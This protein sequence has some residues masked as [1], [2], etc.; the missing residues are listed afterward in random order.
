MLRTI[1]LIL[2]AQLCISA[3]DLG[4]G[5]RLGKFA[6]ASSFDIMPGGSILVC[7]TEKNELI[8]LSPDGNTI[9]SVGGYGWDGENFDNPVHVFATT[10]NVYVSDLNN[11]RIQIFDKDLNYLS[12]FKS[13][14]SDSESETFAYPKSC[15]VSNQGDIFVLDGDNQR[16]L[17]YDLSGRFLQEIGNTDSGEYALNSPASLA[18]SAASKLFVPDNSAIKIFDLFGTGLLKFSVGFD[19][20]AIR[21]RNNYISINSP[22]KIE[23]L[24]LSNSAEKLKEFTPGFGNNEIIVESIITDNFI[25]ILTSNYIIKFQR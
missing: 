6:H 8:K 24:D 25:Y 20:A 10:L 19:V 16:V 9:K 12:E 4:N 15:V 13:R 23:F 2:I 21:I 17:K 11:H 22:T 7:D 3:Q 14:D 5:I 18:V 1:I